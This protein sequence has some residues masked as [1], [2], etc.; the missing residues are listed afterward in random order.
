MTTAVD[1]NIFLDLLAGTESDATLAIAALRKAALDGGLIMSAI[2]YAEIAGRFPSRA[3]VDVF[4]ELL[5]CEVDDIDRETAFLAGQ[6]MRH[7]RQ[8]G[9]GRSRILADFLVAAHAQLRS[10][11]LLSRDKRFYGTSFPRLKAVSPA[12]LV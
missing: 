3:K 5:N 9:G 12:D 2:C 4:L 11:R 10:D 8:R 1:A 7:Y 6:F